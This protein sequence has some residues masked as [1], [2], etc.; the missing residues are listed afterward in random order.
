ME[1]LAIFP[2]AL[3]RPIYLTA[4]KAGRGGKKT[5]VCTAHRILLLAWP[6]RLE[7]ALLKKPFE[8]NTC[9][10]LSIA[11]EIGCS[12]YYSSVS[13]SLGMN[14]NCDWSIYAGRYLGIATNI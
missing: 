13:Y 2:S 8:T 4:H 10:L 7:A 14:L 11:K 1:L 5:S 12:L 6:Q 3:G 9:R